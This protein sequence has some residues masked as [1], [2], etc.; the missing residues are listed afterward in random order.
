VSYVRKL[1][2]VNCRRILLTQGARFYVFER[3]C[4]DNHKDWRPRPV[5]YF[6]V[7]KMR[8]RYVVPAGTDA[9]ETLMSL[10]PARMLER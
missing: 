5:G 3:T 6:N 8:R 1:K 10:T 7:E 2:L 9:L 4:E